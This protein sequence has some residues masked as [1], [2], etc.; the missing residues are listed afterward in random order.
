MDQRGN[1]NQNSNPRNYRGLN[2]ETNEAQKTSKSPLVLPIA[3]A[4][5]SREK[6]SREGGK[7]RISNSSEDKKFKGSTKSKEKANRE[8][9]SIEKG[10]HL[11]LCNFLWIL[12][13]L[14][15]PRRPIT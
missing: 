15:V 12:T 9:S 11:K 13:P 1:K 10:E 5:E 2:Q 6:S 7:S 8:S 3:I 4:N 14:A